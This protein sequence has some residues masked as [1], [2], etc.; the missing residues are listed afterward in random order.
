M[1]ERRIHRA[2]LAATEAGSPLASFR[3]RLLRLPAWTLLGPMLLLSVL[4]AGGWVNIQLPRWLLAGAYALIGW[5]IG[6]GFSRDALRHAGQTLPVVAVAA[7]SQMSFC[8]LL[9]WG[10]IGLAPL[11]TRLVVRHSAHLQASKN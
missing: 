11:I 2:T 10:L 1:P 7:I 6:L 4:R 5:H 9:A 3:K 8:G